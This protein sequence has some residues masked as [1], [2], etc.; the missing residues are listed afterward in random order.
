MG[1]ITEDPKV[2]ECHDYNFQ[3]LHKGKLYILSGNNYSVDAYHQGYRTPQTI[4][5]NSGPYLPGVN[6]MIRLPYFTPIS[7]GDDMHEEAWAL[8]HRLR[9][10]IIFS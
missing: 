8:F 5:R 2:W 3:F 9:N 10:L 4:L 6:E 7:T 1:V